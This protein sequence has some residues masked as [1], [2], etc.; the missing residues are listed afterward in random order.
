ME[1]K[2]NVMDFY[3]THDAAMTEELTEDIQSGRSLF[4]QLQILVLFLSI[5]D[6]LSSNSV[7]STT[8]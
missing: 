6:Y 4:V 2:Q 8:W 1:L 3:Q 5:M 7:I